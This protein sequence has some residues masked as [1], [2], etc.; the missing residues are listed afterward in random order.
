MTGAQ[1]AAPLALNVDVP[2]HGVQIASAMSV[3]ATKRAVAPPVV[4]LPV[5]AVPPVNTVSAIETPAALIHLPSFAFGVQQTRLSVSVQVPVPQAAHCV[6]SAL[7]LCWKTLENKKT[8]RR[9]GIR[10]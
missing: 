5:Q 10:E 9:R 1:S 6:L 8:W 2:V 7:L 3:A 4:V